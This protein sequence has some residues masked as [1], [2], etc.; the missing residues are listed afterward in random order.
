MV[1]KFESA[2]SAVFQKG[3]KISLFFELEHWFLDEF[4]RLSGN[5]NANQ[6]AADLQ[7]IRD[8]IHKR[9]RQKPLTSRTLQQH[10][11]SN[12]YDWFFNFFHW[13]A[14][15]NQILLR[16]NGPRVG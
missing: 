5:L 12:G 14:P 4:Y 7:P 13:T 6:L 2:I 10:N 8:M 3:V 9:L 1:C 16:L 11:L 15:K